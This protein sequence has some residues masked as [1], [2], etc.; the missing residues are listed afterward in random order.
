[1]LLWTGNLGSWTFGLSSD[2]TFL[3]RISIL[4][5]PTS[6]LLVIIA[7]RGRHH[8]VTDGVTLATCIT[9][10]VGL[11]AMLVPRESSSLGHSFDQIIVWLQC[12]LGLAC[13]V[14]AYMLSYFALR[15]SLLRALAPIPVRADANT[16]LHK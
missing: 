14:P 9:I 2:W 4:T 15:H 1:M 11:V 13:I 10:A 6:I 16:R 12:G 3:L 5:L 8:P 7:W